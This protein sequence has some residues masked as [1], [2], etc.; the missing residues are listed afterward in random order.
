MDKW[1]RRTYISKTLK[2]SAGVFAISV[3]PLSLTACNKVTNKTT[4]Q[5]LWIELE[6]EGF[7][8]IKK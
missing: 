1:S 2:E 5:D 6:M 8:Y 4:V 3:L 7:V